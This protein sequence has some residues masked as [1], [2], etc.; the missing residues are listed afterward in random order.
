MTAHDSLMVSTHDVLGVESYEP[1][2]RFVSD[3]S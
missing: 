1:S 2:E 3:V